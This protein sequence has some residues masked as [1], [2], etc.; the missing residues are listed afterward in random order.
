MTGRLSDRPMIRAASIPHLGQT[1]PT[2][3]LG[4]RAIRSLLTRLDASAPLTV[5][6]IPE[7]SVTA[8]PSLRMSENTSFSGGQISAFPGKF[9]KVC[10][11]SP[12]ALRVPAYICGY[13][14]RGADISVALQ[15][16]GF[17][18]LRPAIQHTCWSRASYGRDCREI[19]GNAFRLRRNISKNRLKTWN[20]MAGAAGMRVAV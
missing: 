3:A 13:D 1:T 19:P 10:K 2:A 17:A 20:P 5:L 6:C 16:R 8:H 11:I 4:L 12:G 9:E 18:A 14:A 7:I 15:Y